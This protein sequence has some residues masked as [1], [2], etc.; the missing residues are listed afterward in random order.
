MG[1]G[2]ACAGYLY[3]Q[4]CNLVEKTIIPAKDF[5]GVTANES[6]FP[7]QIPDFCVEDSA[8]SNLGY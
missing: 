7:D 6:M 2:Q 3:R 1:T 4:R 8:K 5:L